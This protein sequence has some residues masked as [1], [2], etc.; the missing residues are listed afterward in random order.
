MHKKS[1]YNKSKYNESKYNKS[2][3]AWKYAWNVEQGKK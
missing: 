2:K 3:Y 1:K